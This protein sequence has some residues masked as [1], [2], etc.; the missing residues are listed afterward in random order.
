MGL[1]YFSVFFQLVAGILPLI[2]L[3]NRIKINRSFILYISLSALTTSLL[4][5]T[6]FFRI[7]NLLIH[8]FYLILSYLLL[9]NFYFSIGE[10]YL[11]KTISV[12]ILVFLIVILLNIFEGGFLK[13]AFVYANIS[14]IIWSTIYFFQLTKTNDN[15]SQS[16][17]KTYSTLNASIFIYNCSA[18][19]LIYFLIT[20]LNNKVWFIHNFIEGSSKLLIAY[21]F[22]KL[23]KTLH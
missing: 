10:K 23:P 6:S 3:F 16:L 4:L 18:F 11:K 17:S 1:L 8:N 20:I 2:F 19:F 5:L 9:A 13:S 12:S 22:W 7:N 14:F 21:A 15:K